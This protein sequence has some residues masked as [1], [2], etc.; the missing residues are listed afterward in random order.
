MTKDI[1]AIAAP[2]DPRALLEAI[3]S[4]SE[5]VQSA[6]KPFH[7]KKRPARPRGKPEEGHGPSSDPELVKRAARGLAG[8]TTNVLDVPRGTLVSNVLYPD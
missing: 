6:N 5:A 2:A 8:Q 4:T 1:P 3:L 7:P